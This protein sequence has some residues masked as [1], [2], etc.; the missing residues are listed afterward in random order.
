[1]HTTLN[2]IS[3]I[4]VTLVYVWMLIKLKNDFYFFT[5]RSHF[6]LAIVI[7]FVNILN[8]CSLTMGPGRLAHDICFIVFYCFINLYTF[9][10][11][12]QQQ[13]FQFSNIPSIFFLV[14]LYTRRFSIYCNFPW[15]VIPSL[16]TFKPVN[17]QK[18]IVH[19]Q[20]RFGAKIFRFF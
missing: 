1:M 19:Y 6:L 2:S 11:T 3:L 5:T 4:L 15:Y 9:R 16:L 17:F 8:Y 14:Q 10:T 12:Q 7:L 20:A 13:K 18:F